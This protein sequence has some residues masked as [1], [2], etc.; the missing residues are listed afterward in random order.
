[1]KDFVSSHIKAFKKNQYS[2]LRNHHR[3]KFSYDENVYPQFSAHNRHFSINDDF[4]QLEALM[5]KAKIDAGKRRCNVKFSKRANA[6]V[7][8]VVSLSYDQ[9]QQ[10][11]IRYPDTWEQELLNSATALSNKIED[12]F[13]LHPMAIDFHADEGHFI[14]NQ[15]IENFHIHITF[16]NFDF[17]KLIHPFRLLGKS[18]LKILQ[19]LTFEAFSRLGFTRGFPRK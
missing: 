2:G 1:M 3:R 14:N 18:A 19:D 9:V 8:N 15:F 12:K 5:E 11:K 16:F 10:V 17:D 4:S 6:F 13:G 7:D